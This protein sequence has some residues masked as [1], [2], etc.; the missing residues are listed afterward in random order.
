MKLY[1]LV[2]VVKLALHSF[3]SYYFR[4]P[5][6]LLMVKSSWNPD[7]DDFLHYY[8]DGTFPLLLLMMRAAV[9]VLACATALLMIRRTKVVV[10]RVFLLQHAY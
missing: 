10:L 9:E 6:I 3:S 2:L 5:R 7:T 1:N 8:F 4:F